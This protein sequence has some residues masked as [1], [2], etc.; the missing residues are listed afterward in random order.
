MRA[1]K[2]TNIFKFNVITL[3]LYLAFAG[4]V[5]NVQAEEAV[6][7][8]G[9]YTFMQAIKDGKSLSSIRPRYENVDEDKL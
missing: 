7:T 1:L 5:T 9:E 8:E 4:V 3:N 2:K 6:E